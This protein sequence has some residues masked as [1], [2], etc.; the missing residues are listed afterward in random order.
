MVKDGKTKLEQQT[1]L[2]ALIIV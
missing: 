2:N 1:S